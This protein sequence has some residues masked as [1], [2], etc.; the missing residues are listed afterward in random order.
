M[1]RASDFRDGD[2]VEVSPQRGDSFSA[3][4]GVVDSRRMPPKKHGLDLLKWVWVRRMDNQYFSFSGGWYPSQCRLIE[5]P[6][7]DSALPIPSNVT[8]GEN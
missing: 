4:Q 7:Q 1:V 3:F 6:V 5:R 8:L 2:I